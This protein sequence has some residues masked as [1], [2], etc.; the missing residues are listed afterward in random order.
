MEYAVAKKWLFSSSGMSLDR[1][2][3]NHH[4]IAPAVSGQYREGK[5]VV[6]SI[7]ALVWYLTYWV[8]GL[9]HS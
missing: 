7:F 3:C 5:S 9:E 2:P 4:L 6:L 1:S 8:V